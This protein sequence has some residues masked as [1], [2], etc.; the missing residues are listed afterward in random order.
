[1]L[2]SRRGRRRE[3]L[4]LVRGHRAL[5]RRLERGAG[6][7]GATPRLQPPDHEQRRALADA[8][9]LA[10][11]ERRPRVRLGRAPLAAQQPQVRADAEHVLH[12]ALEFALLREA[13]RPV[14]V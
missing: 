3:P 2:R 8:E 7:G 13:Q 10:H 11:A 12:V 1:V 4:Q 5:P 6:L 9:L 14:D